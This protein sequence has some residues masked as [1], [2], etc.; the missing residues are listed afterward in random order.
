VLE[1][2]SRLQPGFE[3][4]TVY[5]G[6]D[7]SLGEAEALARKVGEVAGGAEV[8]VIHGGQPHYRYLIAAE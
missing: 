1:A 3:L 4:V 5:Y 7:A 6:A 8:E 2:V